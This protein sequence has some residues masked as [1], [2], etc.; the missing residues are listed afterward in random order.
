MGAEENILWWTEH[1][2]NKTRNDT[3]LIL[4]MK[5]RIRHVRMTTF[6]VSF[7]LVNQKPSLPR[8]ALRH[9]K[10]DLAAHL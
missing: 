1:S 10:D 4:L 3:K 7:V 9:A 6:P 8:D 2:V 5:G